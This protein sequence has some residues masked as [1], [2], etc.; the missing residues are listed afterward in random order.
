MR[1]AD[2]A[3]SERDKYA[4]WNRLEHSVCCWLAE[5]TDHRAA[6][7]SERIIQLE[8]DR[9]YRSPLGEFLVS[10]LEKS[11]GRKQWSTCTSPMR[12]YS[13]PQ[14][15]RQMTRNLS[16]IGTLCCC[17]CSFFGRGCES[18]GQSYLHTLWEIH[19][20]SFPLY[21]FWGI[22]LCFL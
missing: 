6:R 13:E 15:L 5:V 9:G 16:T 14:A 8:I 22:F 17:C 11:I 18:S 3:G 12:S 21:S 2:V 20:M 1:L 4:G 19:T 10:W 7:L